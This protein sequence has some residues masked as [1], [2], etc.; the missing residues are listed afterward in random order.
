MMC[1]PDVCVSFR[2]KPNMTLNSDNIKT[3]F[4]DRLWRVSLFNYKYSQFH[5]NIVLMLFLLCFIY[6]HI[7]CG[8][9]LMP[10]KHT[11]TYVHVVQIPSRSPLNTAASTKSGSVNMADFLSLLP[12]RGTMHETKRYGW[13]DGNKQAFA[14]RWK[15]EG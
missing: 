6:M 2:Y 5:I 10:S 11:C 3:A 4:I 1:L 12:Q 7:F 13:I 14:L 9:S 15:C 8:H